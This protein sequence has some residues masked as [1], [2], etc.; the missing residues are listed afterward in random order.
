MKVLKILMSIPLDKRNFYKLGVKTYLD[1]FDKIQIFH[2]DEGY[3]F[4]KNKIFIHKKIEIIKINYF[5]QLIKFL[6]IRKGSIYLDCTLPGLKT[7]IIK[8]ILHLKKDKIISFRLGILPKLK[9]PERS[10]SILSAIKFLKYFYLAIFQFIENKFL[11]KRRINLCAG[12]KSENE[13]KKFNVIKAHSWD[14]DETLKVKKKNIRKKDFF[15]YLDQWAHGHPDYDYFKFAKVDPKIFYD[16]LNN[17]FD[18]LEKKFK[19]KVIIAAHPRANIYSYFKNKKSYFQNRQIYFNK[20]L[21]L[22][23]KCFATISHDT[24]AISY[25]VI[26]KKPIIFILN[27]EMVRVKKNR[28]QEISVFSKELGSSLI[29]IDKDN[30]SFNNENFFK[31]NVKKYDNYFINYIQNDKKDKKTIDKII[32]DIYSGDLFK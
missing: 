14:F 8:T 18:K 12:R 3:Y 22:S 23:Q 2:I 28:K 9:K 10:Y 25:S 13:Y 31:I 29:N 19:K 17:F 11:I 27:D 32:C 20:T 7:T 15:L 26:Y 6:K 21:E 5:Y 24:T 30:Y 1:F 16:S 4:E